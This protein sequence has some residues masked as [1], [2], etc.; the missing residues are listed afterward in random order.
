[1]TVALERVSLAGVL[2]D[3]GVLLCGAADEAWDETSR[4]LR[5]VTARA[6]ERAELVRSELWS[7]SAQAHVRDAF[8]AVLPPSRAQ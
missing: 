4:L 8:R 2:T 6:P 5:T 3:V 1:M 7:P